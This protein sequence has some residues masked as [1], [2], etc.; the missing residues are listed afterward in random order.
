[1]SI[2]KVQMYTIKCD[3]CSKNVADESEYAGWTDDG[4]AEDEAC[5]SGWI[6]QGKKHYC[7]DCHYYDD[8]SDLVIKQQ[9]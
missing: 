5:D 4:V 9:E 7:K 1:M 2:I 8:N 6:K 3:S